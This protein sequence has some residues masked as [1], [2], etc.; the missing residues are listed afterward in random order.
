MEFD[1]PW[2][3]MEVFD[4]FTSLDRNSKY[5]TLSQL[6][7]L[8]KTRLEETF[9]AEM[10]VV[11]EIAALKVSRNGHCFME[12]VEKEG[13]VL[14]AKVEAL[15]WRD[16]FNR[17]RVFF[18]EATG[19]TLKE[20]L[21]I[22]LL[23]K[24]IFHSVH[25]LRLEIIDIDPSFS[26]GEMMRRRHEIIAR[27]SGE[28][29]LEKNASL[30]LPPVIQRIAVVSSPQA[31]G[32]GDFVHHLQNN[33][34]GYRFLCCLFPAFVQGEE[35]E[36]SL[37]QALEEV[38]KRSDYF[39]VVVIIRGGGS[40]TDLSSFDSYL[41]A[42]RVANFPIPVITGIG[43]QRDQ[44]VLDMVAHTSLKTPTAVAEFIIAH[45]RDFELSLLDIEKRIR[46]K[47]E[48]FVNETKT[49]LEFLKE[50][51]VRLGEREISKNHYML[52]EN[53]REIEAFCANSLE[54]EARVLREFTQRIQYTSR[55]LWREFWKQVEY[56]EDM[57]R[58]LDPQNALRRGY[59]ITFLE[60][61]ILKS[62]GEVVPGQCIETW[63]FNGKLISRV[64]ESY[65]QRED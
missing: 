29:L 50:R 53:F 24:L 16:N 19:E 14:K 36:G 58:L 11:A 7:Q 55:V 62:S 10:W 17:I 25:G 41:L 34:F 28:G 4:F 1:F 30:L 47:A 9:P 61:K 65:E 51:L 18:E 35:A 22:L 48:D 49:V 33:T 45:A 54:K 26:L 23:G 32:W 44:S 2:S 52:R 46:R 5:L 64:E 12:L 59:S 37:I 8:V 40:R 63:L 56:S 57:V 60:G 27:L 39:D 20:G 42:K 38:E 21:K 6:T 15:I 3:E 31:A 13:E 43:H